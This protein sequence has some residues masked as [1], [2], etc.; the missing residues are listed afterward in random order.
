[1]SAAMQDGPVQHYAQELAQYTMRQFS[2]ATAVLD[3]NKKERLAKLPG[4]HARVFQTGSSP[5]NGSVGSPA[6]RTQASQGT[7]RKP[8]RVN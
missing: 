3:D 2:K 8:P 7:G 5:R 6:R 1:M 4:S